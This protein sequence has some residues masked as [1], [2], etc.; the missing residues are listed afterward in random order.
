MYFLYLPLLFW[1]SEEDQEM[2]G[3]RCSPQS[4]QTSNPQRILAAAAGELRGLKSKIV[5]SGKNQTK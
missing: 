1:P 5:P 3:A 2:G 4:G